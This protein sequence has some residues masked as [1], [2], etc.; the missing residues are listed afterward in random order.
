M[1][2]EVLEKAEKS[3]LAK[4]ESLLDVFDHFK[5]N[6]FEIPT[7]ELT[8]ICHFRSPVTQSVLMVFS[9]LIVNSPNHGLIKL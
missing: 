7:R 4:R 8:F 6:V 3:Y 5:L 2:S 1:M 9:I